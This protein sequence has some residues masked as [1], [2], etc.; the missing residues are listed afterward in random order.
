[1]VTRKELGELYRSLSSSLSS[2]LYLPVTT[3]PLGP[4]I[5]L[6]TLFSNTLSLLSSLLWATVKSIR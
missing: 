5:L 4:N 2:F 6:N 3:Y 1:L